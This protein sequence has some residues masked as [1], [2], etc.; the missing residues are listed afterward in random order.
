VI[1]E[2]LDDVT[3]AEQRLLA[4]YDDAIKEVQANRP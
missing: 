4:A 3:A 1:K 2:Y